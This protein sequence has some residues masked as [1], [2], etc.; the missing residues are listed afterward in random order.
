MDQIEDKINSIN[1]KDPDSKDQESENNS[2]I[3][4]L[5]GLNIFKFLDV[6]DLCSAAYVCR[7]VEN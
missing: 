3:I 4:Y 2:L 7:L 5:L 6:K 1:L